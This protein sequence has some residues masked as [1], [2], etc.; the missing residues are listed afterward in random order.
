MVCIIGNKLHKKTLP[1]KESKLDIIQL[2]WI[3]G[4]ITEP[5]KLD[6]LLMIENWMVMKI[7]SM[8]IAEPHYLTVIIIL[9]AISL[10]ATQ[11]SYT[12]TQ[13]QHTAASHSRFVLTT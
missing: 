8:K 11:D 1:K 13:Q 12:Y 6:A 2:V 4:L 10:Q 7:G 3:H 9:A 5:H